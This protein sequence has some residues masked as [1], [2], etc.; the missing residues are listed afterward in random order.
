MT[1]VLFLFLSIS[2]FAQEFQ[3]RIEGS[4]QTTAGPGTPGTPDTVNYSLSWNET[5]T[6]LQGLY[7]DNYFSQQGPNI[8]SGTVE[9]GGRTM[10]VILPQPVNGVR[11]LR[12]NVAGANTGS[13]SVRIATQD[14]V[15]RSIDTVSNFALLS[16]NQA[17]VA[18]ADDNDSC[19]TGFGALTGFC[20]IYNGVFNETS[21]FSNRCNLLTAGNPRLELGA[22]TVLRL[23]LNYLPGSTPG[24]SHT[25]GTFIP[26]PQTTAI[27]ITSRFCAALPGVEFPVGDCKNLNLAGDF[28][29]VESSYS[30][31]GTYTIADEVT[32]ESCSYDMS[33]TREV[34][35]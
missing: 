2:A 20:G 26:S 21:D 3:Y 24:S 8:V 31:I 11:L 35:L 25:I 33:L 32:G 1:Y 10:N 28:R 18:A 12:F 23:Y 9:S 29:N 7:K 27:N 4:F 34:T 14:N 17:Q 6:T 13:T 16:S 19:V 30:F 15:G 5:S 22:D